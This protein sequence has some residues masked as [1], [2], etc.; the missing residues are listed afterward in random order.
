MAWGAIV[1]CRASYEVVLNRTAEK[2]RYVDKSATFGQFYI[3]LDMRVQ[4]SL[5]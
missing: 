2:Y 4:E 1:D 3:S 5:I